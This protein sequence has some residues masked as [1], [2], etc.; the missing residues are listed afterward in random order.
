MSH[1]VV[2]CITACGA[3]QQAKLDAIQA[4]DE[5]AIAPILDERRYN[6]RYSR[7]NDEQSGEANSLNERRSA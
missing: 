3:R 2:T 1:K 4:L 6:F 7:R 5:Q